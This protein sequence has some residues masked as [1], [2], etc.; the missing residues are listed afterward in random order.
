MLIAENIK[1]F[2]KLTKNADMFRKFLTNFYNSWGEEARETLV[3]LQVK[4]CKDSSGSYLR[5]DYEVDGRKEWLHVKGP[6]T[7]Y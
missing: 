1:G 6:N 3:P 7:W 4:F 2:E 5:F